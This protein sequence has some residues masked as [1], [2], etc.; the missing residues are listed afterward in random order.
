LQRHVHVAGGRSGPP[1]QPRDPRP[2]GPDVRAFQRQGHAP[3][4]GDGRAG[5]GRRHSHAA[6]AS[7]T[8]SKEAVMTAF[9]RN[10]R[11]LLVLGLLPGL[12]LRAQPVG[13]E[14]HVNTTTTGQQFRSAVALDAAGNAVVVWQSDVGDG[15]GRAALGQ[16]YDSTGAALGGEFLVNTTTT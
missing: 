4:R 9:R 15:A 10:A 11:F 13:P 14:F 6:S 7:G 2:R 8:L 12:E 1:G 5:R 3:A 16:R